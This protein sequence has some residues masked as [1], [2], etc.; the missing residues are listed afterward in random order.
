MKMT[1]EMPEIVVEQEFPVPCARV[2]Q[3]ITDVHEMREWYFENI[4]DFKAVPGFSC[5]FAVKSESLTFTHLWKVVEVEEH[6]KLSYLWRY[7]KYM[8]AYYSTFELKPDGEA[9]HLKLTARVS[10]DFPAG[11]PEFTREACLAGWQYFIQQRLYEYLQLN[12]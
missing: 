2:W 3:A 12:H 10:E 8:G 4:P 5:E 7:R 9:C 1:T 11:V 6:A